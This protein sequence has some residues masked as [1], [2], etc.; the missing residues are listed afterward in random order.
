MQALETQSIGVPKF[1]A[2]RSTNGQ[3]MVSGNWTAMGAG[4]WNSKTKNVGG[5]VWDG[6]TLTVPRAGYYM[7]AATMHCYVNDFVT[8]AVQV[9]KNSAT[10]DQSVVA[11]AEW[12]APN[13]DSDVSPSATAV[14]LM[15]PLNAGDV[16]RVHG[17]QRNRGADTLNS[18]GSGYDLTLDVVWMD[19]I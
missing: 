7:V 5:F 12:S 10:A 18:G 13:V 9:N 11:K 4:A 8:V 3:T 15:V 16:L 6:G 2:T 14:R 1:A 19:A 17:L